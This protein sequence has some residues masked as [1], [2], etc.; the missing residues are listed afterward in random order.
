MA[1]LSRQFAKYLKQKQ[2]KKKNERSAKVDSSSK[3]VQCFEC[4][5]FGHVRSECANL[6]KQKKKALT[7]I[8]SD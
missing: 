3:N 5:S 6:L 1:L 4:K 7:S 8:K 2:K